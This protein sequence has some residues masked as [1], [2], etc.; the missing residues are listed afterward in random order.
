MSWRTIWTLMLQLMC[1]STTTTHSQTHNWGLNG[2]CPWSKSIDQTLISAQNAP[3]HIGSIWLDQN[4]CQ[5]HDLPNKKIQLWPILKNKHAKC[6]ISLLCISGIRADYQRSHH[7][8]QD[9]HMGSTFVPE[10]RFVSLFPI[11]ELRTISTLGSQWKKVL[12]FSMPFF[13]LITV[14]EMVIKVLWFQTFWRG[15]TKNWNLV[16]IGHICDNI[17]HQ[18]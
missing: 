5:Y 12:V 13:V 1:S 16:W 9:D 11:F 17:V 7:T 18:Q 2:P 4:K 6:P 10:F 3:S 8:Q 14:W 15:R